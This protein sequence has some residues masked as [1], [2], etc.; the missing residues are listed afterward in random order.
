MRRQTTATYLKCRRTSERLATADV[1]TVFPA[2][3]GPVIT[4]GGSHGLTR[5]S[6]PA[7]TRS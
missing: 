2:P 7:A 3:G 5:P 6:S 1:S 4:M